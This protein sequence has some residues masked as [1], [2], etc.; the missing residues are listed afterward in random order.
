MLGECTLEGFW[1]DKIRWQRGDGAAPR[2]PIATG[3]DPFSVSSPICAIVSQRDGMGWNNLTRITRV[4]TATLHDPARLP[5]W[6]TSKKEGKY[7]GPEAEC[8]NRPGSTEE[9]FQGVGT[10][11]YTTVQGHS[12]FSDHIREMVLGGHAASHF[13]TRVAPPLSSFHHQTNFPSLPQWPNST[14]ISMVVSL[15]SFLSLLVRLTHMTK[16]STVPTTMT[17][18]ARPRPLRICLSSTP[19]SPTTAKSP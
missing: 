5:S 17:S 13:V 6:K 16:I 1:S 12:E 14:L 19:R 18:P 8:L 9:F 15:L 7:G 10:C 11:T 4:D 3:L 2:I